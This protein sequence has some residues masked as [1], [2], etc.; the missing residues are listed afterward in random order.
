MHKVKVR[1]NVTLNQGDRMW[2]IRHVESALSREFSVEARSPR[3][4]RESFGGQH[5]TLRTQTQR[6]RALLT[7][8]NF[9]ERPLH[10]VSSYA[11]CLRVHQWP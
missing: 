10:H 1:D 8:F 11:P 9:Y 6:F 3:T 7:V 5:S 4:P 2:G